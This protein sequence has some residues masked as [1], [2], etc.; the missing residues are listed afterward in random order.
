MMR[1]FEQ[2]GFD[3]AVMVLH[4]NSKNMERFIPKAK[5]I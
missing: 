4:T 2:K 1:Y 3:F 5:E